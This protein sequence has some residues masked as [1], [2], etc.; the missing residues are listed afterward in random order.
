MPNLPS[1]TIVV[2]CFN[3]GHRLVESLDTL[4]S[5]FPDRTEIVV[6]D[7]GSTDDT[8]ERLRGYA[9]AHEGI[10][11]HHLP[12]NRGKGGAIREAIPRARGTLVVVMDADLAYDRESV[13]RVIDGLAQA[14]I[15]IGNRRHPGSRYSVPVRL[16]GFVYRRHFAGLVFNTVLRALIPVSARDTQCGLKGFR[17][18]ALRRIGR[19]VTTDGFALDVEML[20]VAR[21]LGIRV[22]DAPVR[23]TYHSAKSSVRLLQSAFTMGSDVLRIA[24]RRMAGHYSPDRLLAAAATP[25]IQSGEEPPAQQPP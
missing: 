13:Q 23:V 15:V 14:E 21:G 6:V 4:R 25:Q 11:V 18:D 9:E 17:L 1:L 12:R 19:S 8:F 20:L 2:P 16:F 24:V 10:D 22:A 5:W 3:E 7:D